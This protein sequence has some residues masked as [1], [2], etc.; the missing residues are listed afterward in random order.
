MPVASVAPTETTVTPTAGSVQ[1]LLA[2]PGTA[3]RF[4]VEVVNPNTTHKLYIATSSAACT[5]QA[6]AADP[7]GGV[8]E[9]PL[10]TNVPLYCLWESGATAVAVRIVQYVTA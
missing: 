7:N 4:W 2:S 9:G 5:A 1:T 3:N 8:W 10:G 6:K